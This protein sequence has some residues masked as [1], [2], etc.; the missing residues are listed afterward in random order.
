MKPDL[1]NIKNII[2]DLGNVLLNLDLGATRDAFKKLGLSADV[3]T[4][5]QAYADPAF[6]RFEVGHITPGEFRNSIRSILNNP[7]LA[8]RQIDDAW[9]AMLL[10]MPHQR[11][12]LLKKLNKKYRLYLFSNT[13]AIHVHRLHLEFREVHGMAL[14]SLFEKNY[15]SHQIHARKPHAEA[16]QKVLELSKIKPEESLFIDDL[17]KNI[18]GAAEAGMKTFWLQKEMEVTDIF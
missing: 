12:Q 7:N 18:E 6:Y 4:P 10:D 13:N 1:T 11:V 5:E 2:F 8:D 14:S 16:Y 17:K 9:C 15:Y 3:V